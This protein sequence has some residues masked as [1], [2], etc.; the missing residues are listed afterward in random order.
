MQTK[1]TQIYIKIVVLK[2]EMKTNKV[3]LVEKAKRSIGR[4]GSVV[5]FQ[6][7]EGKNE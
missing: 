1:N 3:G 7:E 2:K 5:I 4:T 6:T